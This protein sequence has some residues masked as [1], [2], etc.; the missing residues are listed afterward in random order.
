MLFSP[1]VFNR[2]REY[3][4]NEI[5]G[6]FGDLKIREQLIL[7]VKYVEVLVLLA[8]EETVLQGMFDRLFEI[9]GCYGMEMNL[10]T[11]LRKRKC[12]GNH[13]MIYYKLENVKYLKYCGSMITNKAT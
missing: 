8:E 9:T 12:Q 6:S 1:T 11:K 7:P 2:Y 5:L 4:S 13:I 3:L 10:K